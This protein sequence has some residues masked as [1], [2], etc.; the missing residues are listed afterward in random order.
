MSS[1]EFSERPLR[2]DY[3]DCDDCELSELDRWEKK[4][5][6]TLTDHTLVARYV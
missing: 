4:T 1:E 6:E 5:H 3:W 2:I